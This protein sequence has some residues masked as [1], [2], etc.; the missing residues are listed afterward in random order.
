[1]FNTET[2]HHQVVQDA[3]MGRRAADEQ[4]LTCLAVLEDK[5]ERLKKL[6]PQFAAVGLSPAAKHLAKRY[7]SAMAGL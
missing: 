5:L 1:M 7:S 2:N 4:V 3:I 6:G